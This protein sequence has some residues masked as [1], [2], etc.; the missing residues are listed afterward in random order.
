M[1]SY[2]LTILPYLDSLGPNR[3]IIIVSP[4][5]IQFSMQAIKVL[6]DL[7]QAIEKIIP[8]HV[9][10][11]QNLDNYGSPQHLILSYTK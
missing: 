8:F 11:F 3:S 1:L 9:S 6:L 7:H 5:E 2:F 10:Y 4:Y